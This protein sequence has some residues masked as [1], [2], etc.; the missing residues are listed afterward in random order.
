MP[1]FLR[2]TIFLAIS[3]QNYYIT[4]SMEAHR[5]ISYTAGCKAFKNKTSHNYMLE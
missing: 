4:H 5:V 1:S 3:G 2:M